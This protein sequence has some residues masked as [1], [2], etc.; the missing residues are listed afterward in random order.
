MDEP[1]SLHCLGCVSVLGLGTES[2]P[3]SGRTTLVVLMSVYTRVRALGTGVDAASGR[4]T[5]DAFK[6][7]YTQVRAL[8]TGVDA[9]SGRTTLVALAFLP[10]V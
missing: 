3:P 1:H 5:L 10:P 6:D 7:V 4:T 8:G 2:E 9:L